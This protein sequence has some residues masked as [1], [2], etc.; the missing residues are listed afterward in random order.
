MRRRR[1]ITPTT[2]GSADE[3]AA[4]QQGV[5]PDP[6]GVSVCGVLRHPAA[7]DGGELLGAGHHQPRAARV[8][9]RGL[10][11]PDPARRRS[12][13]RAHAPADL[14][15]VRAGRGNSAGHR[16]G[17]VDAVQGLEGVGRTGGAGHAAADSL[18]R[19]GH[20]LAD[21]RALRYRPGRLLAQPDGHRLQLHVALVRRVD[22]CADHGRVALDAA[23]SAAGLCRPALD[24]GC[25]LP[26]RRD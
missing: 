2:R 6:A 12:A 17:A 8:R 4:Q 24:P 20:H 9:G 19:G 11:P 16:P 5:V 18:E 15:A 25:V 10:V 23:G 26:G 7:D 22:H 13:G 1:C 21:L 3:Q 14:L